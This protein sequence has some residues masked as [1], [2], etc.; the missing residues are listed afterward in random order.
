VITAKARASIR[1]FLKHQ[2][3]AE[4][5]R[6]GRRLLNTALGSHEL[7]IDDIEQLRIATFLKDIG[8]DSFDAL[9]KDIGLGN[10]MA[11]LVVRRLLDTGN[12]PMQDSKRVETELPLAIQGTEGMVV[13]FG[14]CCQPIPGDPIAGLMSA[15]RGLVIHRE[16]CR[17]V[18]PHRHKPDK[19]I[20]VFW[21]MHPIGEFPTSIRVQSANQ[22]GVLAALA[23]KISDQ[24]S[25]IENVSFEERD[26]ITSTIIFQLTVNSRLHLARIMRVIRNTPEV[27]RVQRIRG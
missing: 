22:R 7:T 2:Q 5:I 3:H 20:Q 8:L 9:L 4:A 21:S 6:L 16:S 1:H 17:N 13:S 25:N 15:G 11:Q 18:S 10:R 14:K 19:W 12:G 27:Y 23:S 24:G 26:G